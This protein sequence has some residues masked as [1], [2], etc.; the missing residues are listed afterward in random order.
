MNCI[1]EDLST[2]AQQ[3]VN[4]AKLENFLQE[5]KK[6]F[7]SALIILNTTDDAMKYQP[8]GDMTYGELNFMLDITKRDLIDQFYGIK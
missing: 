3:L 7:H 5:N 4:F 2:R 6:H 1:T 8:F